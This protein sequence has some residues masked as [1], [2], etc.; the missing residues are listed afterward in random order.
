[1]QTGLAGLHFGWPSPH[2]ARCGG[3]PFSDSSTANSTDTRL[4]HDMTH[5]QAL[6]ADNSDSLH[7]AESPAESFEAELDSVPRNGDLLPRF[8]CTYDRCVRVLHCNVR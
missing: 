3:S 8:P 5:L 2:I 4:R 1:M 6:T 7:D